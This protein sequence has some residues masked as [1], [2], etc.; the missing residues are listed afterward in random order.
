MAFRVVG[1]C[2]G[3]N[4]E[5]DEFYGFPSIEEEPINSQEVIITADDLHLDVDFDFFRFKVRLP[6]SGKKW[7]I[8]LF[9]LV[10]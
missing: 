5:V 1:T 6:G 3:C 10:G 4:P 7:E 2:R 9:R 8:L